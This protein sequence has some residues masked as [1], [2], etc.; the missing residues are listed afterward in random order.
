MEK[1]FKEIID[2][3]HNDYAG[4]E[5]KRGW[6]RP[7]LFLQRIMENDQL[8]K[9]QFKEF[10]DEYLLDFN[11]RHIHF[12]MEDTEEEKTQNRGFKVRRYEDS[13]FVTEADAEKRLKPGVRFI[14]LGGK[15]IPELKELHARRLNES[16]QE[17]EDWTSLLMLYPDGEIEDENGKRLFKFGNYDKKAYV[18][19]YSVEKREGIAIITMTDFLNPDAIA[20]MVEA[21]KDLLETADR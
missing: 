19:T 4:F 11:D 20:E 5:D 6:D 9:K 7:E 1:M 12:I 3:M 21:N 13:L 2:I 16:H 8:T 17:R 14:S 18:P 15:S 10:V